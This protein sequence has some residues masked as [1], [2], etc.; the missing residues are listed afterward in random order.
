VA[1]VMMVIY[2]LVW[3][4]YT[5][6]IAPSIDLY[7]LFW[8]AFQTATAS[9]F[10][11]M[12]GVSLQLRAERL[13][14]RGEA[15]HLWPRQ[16]RRALIVLGASLLVTIVTALTVPDGVVVFGILHCIGVSILL[17][18]PFL[19]L[20]VWNVVPGL[21]VIALGQAVSNVIVPTPWLVWLGLRFPGFTTVD[22]FPLLPWFGVVLLGL[23][24]GSL[25]YAGGR[26]PPLPDASDAPPV[27]LLGWLGRH[28]LIIYLVHQPI[29]VAV[30]IVTGLLP[31]SQLR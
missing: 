17:A 1:I 2:H 19:R 14:Q 24:L 20:G 7:G 5:Y 26:R 11:L 30:L 29:I 13:R 9:L 25:A 10:L 31:L 3:D 6:Q 23:A 16:L 8:R 12:V 21:A 28:S 22:Y 15:D 4:L 27:R 18:Y